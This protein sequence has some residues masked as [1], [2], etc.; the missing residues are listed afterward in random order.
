MAN[1]SNERMPAIKFFAAIGE[2]L[3]KDIRTQKQTK[4]GSIKMLLNIIFIIHE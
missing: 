4:R 1:N 3:Y 2:D